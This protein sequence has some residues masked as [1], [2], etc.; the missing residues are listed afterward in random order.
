L[1]RAARLVPDGP[2]GCGAVANNH[3]AAAFW[4]DWIK[5][6]SVCSFKF[7]RTEK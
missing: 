6:V 1:R 4:A 3:F 2:A 7:E 5:E